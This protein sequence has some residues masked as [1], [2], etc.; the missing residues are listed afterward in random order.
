MT[1][2]IRPLRFDN[3][4]PKAHSWERPQTGQLAA[5]VSPRTA[6]ELPG[7]AIVNGEPRHDMRA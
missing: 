6:R 7:S 2:T 1:A 3:G 4:P 5:P